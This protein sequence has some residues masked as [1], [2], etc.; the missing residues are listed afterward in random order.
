MLSDVAGWKEGIFS[1]HINTR[2]VF[3]HFWGGGWP[4]LGQDKA[5]LCLEKF[6]VSKGAWL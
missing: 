2:E 6:H 5:L 1:L 3:P 4:I